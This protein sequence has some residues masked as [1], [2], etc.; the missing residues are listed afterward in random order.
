MPVGQL[1][2]QQLISL[3]QLFKAI[4]FAPPDGSVRRAAQ[5]RADR[6]PPAEEDRGA[7]RARVTG[8]A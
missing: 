2:E 6:Q 7:N 5:A 8:L 1:T 4:K 3:L